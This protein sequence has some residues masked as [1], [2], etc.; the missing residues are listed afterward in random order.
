MQDWY[1]YKV[2]YLYHTIN[3]RGRISWHTIAKDGGIPA[4]QQDAQPSPKVPH[5]LPLLLPC[6]AC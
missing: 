4:L 1:N 2:W 3:M 6:L 5:S